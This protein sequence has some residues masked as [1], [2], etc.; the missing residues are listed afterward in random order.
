MP[1]VAGTRLDRAPDS[2]RRRRRSVQIAPRI[3]GAEDTAR[4]RQPFVSVDALM[5]L[6]STALDAAGAALQSARLYFSPEELHERNKSLASER[7][8]TARLLEALANDQLGSGHYKHLTLP[9]WKARRLLGLPL[10]VDACVFNLDGVLIG[11]A[12]LHAAAWTQTFDELISRR[13]ERTGAHL[14][15]FNPRTDYPAHIHGRPRLEGVRAFLAH[16]GIRLP[17]GDP[18]DAPG[19]ETVH[20]LANR[21]NQALRR[22]IQERGVT[23]FEGSRRY[24]EL[25]RDAGIHRGVVSASANTDAILARAG[26]T[27]VI[28]SSIDGSTIVAEH[29]RP[30]PATDILLAACR[31][32]GV[33][34]EHAAVFET[35]PAGVAAGRAGGFKLVIGI[36]R[37]GQANALRAAGAHIVVSGLAELL[38]RAAALDADRA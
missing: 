8:A 2:R 20:G 23:A 29:L 24:L 7:D 30:R 33:A 17:E 11:S 36:D 26:F 12:S 4:S 14:P 19:M 22:L 31:Q 18:D 15:P 21:K 32:L 1:L 3:D 5:E 27:H 38:D 16:R 10:G 9:P 28:D 34:P 13:V 6:W 35:S 25:V 37:A